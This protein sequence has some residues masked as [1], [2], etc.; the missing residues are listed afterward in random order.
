MAP[1]TAAVPNVV[2]VHVV[3]AAAA[4]VADDDDAV[5]VVAG[6]VAHVSTIIV[7]AAAAHSFVLNGLW[8][9][10]SASEQEQTRRLSR[11]LQQLQQAAA[12]ENKAKV[13][14]AQAPT[15]NFS[16]KATHTPYNVSGKGEIVKSCERGL[17]S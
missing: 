9:V 14:P 2:S 1:L 6:A 5:V 12:K 3:V 8:L 11:Q 15:T 7:V 10:Q 16:H 4:T 13:S 17:S